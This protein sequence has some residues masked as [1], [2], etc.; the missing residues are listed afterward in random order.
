MVG[1]KGGGD[2][3]T[4]QQRL[5]LPRLYNRKVLKALREFEMLDP[6]D[7]ILVGFS[8][9]KDSALL[10]YAL[11]VLGRYGIVEGEVAAITVD[12]G[13]EPLDPEPL[14]E[15]CRLL[16][17]EHYLVKTEIGRA[18]AG[19]DDPCARCSHL[20]RGIICRFAREHGYNKVALG[21]HHDDA[22]ETFLMSILYSGQIRTFLPKTYLDRSGV[23]VIR[24]LVYLREREVKKAA[25]FLPFTPVKP[26]C[27]YAGTSYRQKVK[28]L[29][30]EL[31]RERRWVYTNLAAAMREGNPIQLWP[32]KRSPGLFKAVSEVDGGSGPE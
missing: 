26:V 4:G 23:T 1:K 22:V 28:E 25:S 18:V 2:I 6:G 21:H 7:R 13:M 20:R 8:G 30:R 27:S 12:P 29:L 5:S 17:V 3:V 24:P 16:G 14:G 31:T 32:A 9:G 11:V 19:F 10:L 15:Y